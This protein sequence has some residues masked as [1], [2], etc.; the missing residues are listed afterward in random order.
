MGASIKEKDIC[1]LYALHLAIKAI[2]ADYVISSVLNEGSGFLEKDGGYFII[3][4]DAVLEIF[5]TYKIPVNTVEIER[6]LTNAL[7]AA[8]LS[9]T[10]NEFGKMPKINI[11]KIGYGAGDEDLKM[12]NLLRV[13]SG[14]VDGGELEKMFASEDLFA[15]I[16]EEL[17][18]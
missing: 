8:V 11:E 5:K 13:V 18:V 10:A 15:E 12:P 16:S 6:E 14:T 1:T 7:S 17:F 3:P 9:Q 2:D 4:S